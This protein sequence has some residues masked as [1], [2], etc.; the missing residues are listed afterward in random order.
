MPPVDPRRCIGGTC[1][2]KATAVSNDSRR[3]YG[4]EA[5]KLWLRGTV[6]EVVSLRPEGSQRASTYIKAKYQVGNVEKIKLILISQLRKEDP[7]AVTGDI[8]AVPPSIAP[9]TLPDAANPATNNNNTANPSPPANAVPPPEG[10]NTSNQSS[11]RVPVATAHNREWFDGE[12]ELPTN[13]PFT[14]KTWKL[15]CQYTG[16]E[17]TPGCDSAARELTALEFFM[18]VFPSSQLN[19]MVEATSVQ[20]VAEGGAR[21]TK[22]EVLKWLGILLL[23]TRFEFGDRRSLWAKK[24]SCKYVP[25][26]NLG[27]RTG[28]S[29]DWFEAL[30]CCMIWSRQPAQRPEGMSHEAYRWLLVEDFVH[31]FNEHREQFFNPSWGLCADESISRWYGLGGHWINMGLPMYVSMDRKPEDGLE[32]QDICCAKSGIMCRLKL[33]KTAAANAE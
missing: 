13:G 7:A 24:S 5:N 8:A 14:R 15:T 29:R 23:I 16:K 30:Q 25:A 18:A 17:F 20:L 2:A 19:L 3:I 27:E 10:T 4:V 12:V 9:D 33:V 28:M 32:I 6:L 11:V 1:W 26:A 22:G 21:T 31:N